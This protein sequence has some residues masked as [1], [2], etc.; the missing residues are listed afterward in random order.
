VKAAAVVE[1]VGDI[2]DRHCSARDEE[3]ERLHCAEKAC[4][5]RLRKHAKVVRPLA[6]SFGSFRSA[7]TRKTVPKNGRDNG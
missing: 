1:H 3:L 4:T 5:S 7:R 2:V 6:F